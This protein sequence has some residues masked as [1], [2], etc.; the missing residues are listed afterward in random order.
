MNDDATG[1][2]LDA[3][4]G[5]D[6]REHAPGEI[7]IDD[8][9]ARIRAGKD[10]PCRAIE[11][12]IELPASHEELCDPL[13]QLQRTRERRGLRGGVAQTADVILEQR[14]ARGEDGP[15]GQRV[16]GG[17]AQQV[18]HQAD[19]GLPARHVIVEKRID[20]LVADIEL[21]RRCDDEALLFKGRQPEHLTQVRQ[22]QPD[23]LARARRLARGDARVHP[24]Q[25]L[26]PRGDFGVG[27][28][29]LLRAHV[30]EDV[31][32]LLLGDH[33]SLESIQSPR[34][35][36]TSR[37]AQSKENAETQSL[38]FVLKMFPAIAIRDFRGGD[39]LA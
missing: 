39:G 30:S 16:L 24:R 25:R 32:N 10:E 29:V 11:L 31:G 13:V 26:H 2:R 34:W 33:Q 22:R 35:L 8:D 5:L 3:A 6:K 15:G 4:A 1:F 27:F 18:Q 12:R 37:G 28:R 19:G 20:L 17:G 21:R 23:L 7:F 36:A 14:R 38:Q 9:R